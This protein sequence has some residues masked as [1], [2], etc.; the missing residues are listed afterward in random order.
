[1]TTSPAELN[2]KLH[3]T[4]YRGYILQSNDEATLV[5]A[6]ADRDENGDPARWEHVDTVTL[7]TKGRMRTTEDAARDLVDSWMEAR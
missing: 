3:Y 4:M 1:M 2:L 6:G 5:F 7:Q